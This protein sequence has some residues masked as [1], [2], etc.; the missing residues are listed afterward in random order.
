MNNLCVYYCIVLFCV[1][2]VNYRIVFIGC[3]I[4]WFWDYMV[5]F[6]CVIFI[7]INVIFCYVISGIYRCNFICLCMYMCVFRGLLCNVLCMNLVYCVNYVEV[8][9]YMCIFV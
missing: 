5:Y 3:I 9:Y 6:Y 2:V 1:Y 8:L 4:Y 7:G